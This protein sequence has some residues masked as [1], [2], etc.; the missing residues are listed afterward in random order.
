MPP[1]WEDIDLGGE[2]AALLKVVA[3]VAV[4]FRDT[5]VAQ[6]HAYLV[7]DHDDAAPA[8][9]AISFQANNHSSRSWENRT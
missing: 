4:E 8:F 2:N 1:L 7:V 3:V 9:S 6:G 5:N